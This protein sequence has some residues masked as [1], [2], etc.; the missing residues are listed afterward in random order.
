M[1][2]TLVIERC[3]CRPDRM[4]DLRLTS[5][6]DPADLFVVEGVRH[7]DRVCAGARLKLP[8]DVKLGRDELLDFRQWHDF[9]WSFFLG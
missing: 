9:H 2:A 3:R 7:R 8:A 5:G 6:R 4:L 1:T